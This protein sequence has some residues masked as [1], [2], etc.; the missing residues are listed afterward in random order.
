MRDGKVGKILE[1]IQLLFRRGQNKYEKQL[2][3]LV[4]WTFLVTFW[5][6]LSSNQSKLASRYL[7]G[8]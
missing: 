1:K 2:L 6:V 5:K 7:L 8:M 3:D 4:F